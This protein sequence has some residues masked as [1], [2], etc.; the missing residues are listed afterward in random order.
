[1]HG[2]ARPPMRVDSKRQRLSV[3]GQTDRSRR[4]PHQ[5]AARPERSRQQPLIRD[6]RIERKT[7]QT[8]L[9]EQRLSMTPPLPPPATAGVRP[10]AL[11]THRSRWQLL[12]LRRDGQTHRLMTGVAECVARRR[13]RERRGSPARPELHR[14]AV[15]IP[16]PN[17]LTSGNMEADRHSGARAAALVG[18]RRSGA[19]KHCDRRELCVRRVRSWLSPQL[20][21]AAN[22]MLRHGTRSLMSW[23]DNVRSTPNR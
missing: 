15:R 20:R 9:C 23:S 7:H 5:G 16:S 19:P 13:S 12:S 14:C 3:D 22:G 2:R 17:A 4:R 8:S 1:M 10:S 6:C 11:R 21:L 18:G